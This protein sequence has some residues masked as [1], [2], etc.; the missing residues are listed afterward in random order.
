MAVNQ[1]TKCVAPGDEG[2]VVIRA[3]LAGLG[4]GSFWAF[5][6]FVAAGGSIAS[7]IAG[8]GF[9]AA[10]A[11]IIAVCDYFFNSRLICV[12]DSDVLVGIL[13][14]QEEAFDG[15]LCLNV[16]TAPFRPEEPGPTLAE[17][18]SSTAPQRRF[19][20]LPSNMTGYGFKVDHK[21]VNNTNRSPLIHNEIEGTKMQAWCTATIAA[22]AAASF[23]APLAVA[24]CAAF[25][26]F[27]WLCVLV[28]MVVIALVVWGISELGR[29]LGDTGAISDVAVDPEAKT[30]K[31]EDHP[32]IAIEG[33]LIYDA[34]HEG[35]LE[36]HAVRKI[37]SIPE[38][39]H[40]N[41]DDARAK[42]I[43]ELI[44]EADKLGKSGEALKHVVSDHERIG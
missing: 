28:A 36:L 19:L 27:W 12:A 35:W 42:E 6:S 40:D 3:I 10:Y 8:F 29:A 4:F 24:G 39:D 22:L 33:R 43:A 2:N 34:G 37:M 44:R 17:M 13:W 30:V 14:T 1:L 32:T 15:D 7:L 9:A 21:H 41:F 25:G 20:M 38:D 26:P 31:A 16:L 18:T 11:V 23:A 5:I